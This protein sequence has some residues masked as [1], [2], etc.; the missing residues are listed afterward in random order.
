MMICRTS[1]GRIWLRAGFPAVA[2][3]PYFSG[4]VLLGD[5]LDPGGFRRLVCGPDA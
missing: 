4:L 1:C 2:V 3:D 5:R